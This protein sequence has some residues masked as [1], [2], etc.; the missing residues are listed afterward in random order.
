MKT[1]FRLYIQRDIADNG[2]DLEICKRYLD[3]F[4]QKTMADPQKRYFGHSNNSYVSGMWRGRYGH[5]INFWP[6]YQG[7]SKPIVF[8][9]ISKNTRKFAC[10][11]EDTLMVKNDKF[12]DLRHFRY[13]KVYPDGEIPNICK[14]TT[15]LGIIKVGWKVKPEFDLYFEYGSYKG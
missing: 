1:G 15:H 5:Q 13:G 10:V 8:R 3:D 12:L 11:Y 4:I 9:R 14:C 6:N 7:V 2:G